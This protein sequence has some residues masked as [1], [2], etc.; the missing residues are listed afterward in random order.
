[1]LCAILRFFGGEK[2]GEKMR[3]LKFI[4]T[5]L[6]GNTTAFVW[7]KV[8]RRQQPKIARRLMRPE[9]LGVEQVGFIEKANNSKAE[10]LLQMMGGEI[11]INAT[12]S[13]VFIL[14][15][16]LKKKEFYLD[17]SGYPNLIQCQMVNNQPEIILKQKIKNNLMKLRVAGAKQLIKLVDLGGIAYFLI[18]K[19]LY[20]KPLDYLE[21]FARVKK[22]VKKIPLPPAWGI[23]FYQQNKIQPIVYVKATNSVVAEKACGSGSLAFAVAENYQNIIQPSGKIIKVRKNKNN[24][25]ISG[26][27]KL[28]N[29]GFVYI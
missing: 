26:K 9:I 15:K 29:E 20:S 13:L 22:Q 8:S 14:A 16:K 1:M 19:N 21:E 5:D 7:T 17:L 6:A 4:Q 18:D 3:K 27:A 28:I 2:I 10:A 25:S 23:I 11:S 24:I 12:L